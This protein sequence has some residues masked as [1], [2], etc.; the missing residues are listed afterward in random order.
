MAK[1]VR[2]VQGAL[3]A[4]YVHDDGD[5]R[6]PREREATASEVGPGR[7]CSKYQ[8]MEFNSIIEGLNALKD[9]LSILCQALEWDTGEHNSAEVEVEHVS[10]AEKGVA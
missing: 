6:G 9:S 2:E 7:K 10:R 4:R 3:G 5:G 1:P 8:M